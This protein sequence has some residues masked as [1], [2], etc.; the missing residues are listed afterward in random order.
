MRSITW[1]R[2]DDVEADRMLVK[3]SIVRSLDDL[4]SVKSVISEPTN[5]W[6][7]GDRQVVYPSKIIRS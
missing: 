1:K 5:E 2:Y 4:K 3:S 6:F 7:R